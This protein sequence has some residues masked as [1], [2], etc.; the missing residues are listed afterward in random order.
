MIK[1][2]ANSSFFRNLFVSG[3][4]DWVLFLA[5]LPL[6]AAGLITMRTF[7]GGDD[8][9]FSRQIIWIAVSFAVFFLFSFID[10]RFLK[11]GEVLISLFGVAIAV[12]VG[13]LFLGTAVKGAASWI[14]LPF[15]AIQPSDPIKILIIL[16]LA[17]YFS[18]RHIEIANIRHIIIS[19]IY[20]LILTILIFFQP[21]FGS[22]LIFFMI[23][24]GM[25]M[26]SGVSKKH[27]LLVFM[28]FAIIFSVSWFFVFQPYQKDRV[29]TFLNPLR[30]VRGAGYSAYQS[31]IAVGSGQV[32][33]K[34]IGFG[35]QSR[36][37]FLPEYQTDFVFAAFTEEWGLVGALFIFIFYGIV[38]WR[39]LK[40]AF[41]GQSNFES[42]FGM[43]L[44]ILLMSHF[45][46]HVG[47]NIGLMPITGIPL[48]F[49]SYGGSHMI[50]VFAG[51]GILMGMRKY[52][53]QLR[54]KDIGEEF[55]VA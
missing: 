35:T 42:F 18:R 39:I 26:V 2:I 22:A 8:Y 29:L 14:A 54:Y 21:D 16:I 48:P 27:L 32:F 4:I 38:I 15:F 25:I 6:L 47:M 50:T 46:I 52:S 44:A 20:V 36:L 3:R 7:G 28:I 19:G 45:I 53:H 12:L 11:K 10:W 37:E 17:K 31:M 5:T 24:L 34:G 40:N 41:L 9:F 13:L 43:G 1:K 33:G 49:L 30:D 55:G 51:L 23:W